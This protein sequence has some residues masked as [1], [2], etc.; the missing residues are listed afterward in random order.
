MSAVRE[1]RL[2]LLATI[3]L[4]IAAVATAWSTFQSGR[5]RGDQAVDTNRALAAHIESSEAHTRAG[6]LTQID[7]ATF[8]QW[9]D[10]NAADL[11][12][13]MGDIFL[14]G[15]LNSSRPKLKVARSK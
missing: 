4:A 2:E 9:V 14:H 3:L 8:I 10:A 12:K 13:Q 1:H 7:I 15:V 11:A 5:W 6:Q